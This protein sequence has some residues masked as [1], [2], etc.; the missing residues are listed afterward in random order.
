MCYLGCCAVG[1]RMIL[2]GQIRCHMCAQVRDINTVSTSI[3]QHKP[4]RTYC[5][6]CQLPVRGLYAWCQGCGHGGH[7]SHM[8]Q[9]FEHNVNCPAGCGHRCQLRFV[10]PH[11]PTP[12]PTPHRSDADARPSLWELN[13]VSSPRY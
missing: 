9:W 8:R 13:G 7:A 5:S 6:V 2:T 11:L 1:A 4:P 3:N 10:P 12:V